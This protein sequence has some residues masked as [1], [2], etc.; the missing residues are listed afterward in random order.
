MNVLLDVFRLTI[1]VS[2]HRT[3]LLLCYPVC[4]VTLVI[5]LSQ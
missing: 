4:I 1:L 2:Y 3:V 5:L